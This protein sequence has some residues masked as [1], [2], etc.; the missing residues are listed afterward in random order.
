VPPFSDVI[1]DHFLGPRHT[2]PLSFVSGEGWGGTVESGRYIRIQVAVDEGRVV[3]AAFAT[4]GCA[5]AIAAGSYTCEWAVGRTVQEALILTDDDLD[6]A[7]GHIPESRRYYANLAVEAL[8]KALEKAIS[9]TH[10]DNLQP[11]RQCD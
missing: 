7:L 11:P 1:M 8:S 5:P 4:V 6:R 9:K 10:L 3:D 2:A